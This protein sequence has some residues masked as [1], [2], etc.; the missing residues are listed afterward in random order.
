MF[1]MAV[2]V[3]LSLSR[4]NRCRDF[5]KQNAEE[6][7]VCMYVFCLVNVYSL[8]CIVTFMYNI[9]PFVLCVLV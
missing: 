3:R 9:C 8:F 7:D 4:K 5:R 1:Y 2:E 6:H